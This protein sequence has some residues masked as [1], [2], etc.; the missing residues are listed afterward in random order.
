MDRCEE[1]VTDMA[2]LS[3]VG[4]ESRDRKTAIAL[5]NIMILRARG[6]RVHLH[7]TRIRIPKTMTVS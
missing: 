2:N 5:L 4:C 3:L 7:F 6:V 1:F